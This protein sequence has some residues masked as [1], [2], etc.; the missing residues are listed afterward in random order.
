M[1][2]VNN[3]GVTI[4]VALAETDSPLAQKALGLWSEE[5]DRLT[6]TRADSLLCRA[7]LRG[8]IADITHLSPDRWHIAKSHSGKPVASEDSGTTPP[9]ISISHSGSW[10]ACAVS[11]DGDVGIDVEVERSERNFT[12]IASRAFGPRE[13]KAIEK[14]G[15]SRFYSIWTLRE[16]I[17]KAIGAG[18][19][20]V[21]DSKDRV[22]LGP[23]EGD[24]QVELD[25]EDWFL[26][27]ASPKPNLSLGIAIRPFANKPASSGLRVR[28]WLASE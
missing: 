7:L 4:H 13:V 17:S 21:A 24:R 23:H 15:R 25:G 22:A 14:H 20:M 1:D 3:L 16:A 19:S 5:A 10:S 27:H 9:S 12:G 6:T 2:Q 18:L 26:V 8:M 28:W 11:F